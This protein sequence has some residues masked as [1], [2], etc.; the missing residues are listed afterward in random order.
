MILKAIDY[1]CRSEIKKKIKDAL[2]KTRDEILSRNMVVTIE[3]DTDSTIDYTDT[4]KG[5]DYI[6]S[7]LK[8]SL[9]VDVQ[10]GVDNHTLIARL[11]REGLNHASKNNNNKEKA[12]LF[13][14]FIKLADSS[15]YSYSTVQ[16]KKHS[17]ASAKIN[18]KSYWDSFLSVACFE[19]VYYNVIFS[20][21]SID[22]DVRGQI[23]DSWIKKEANASHGVGTQNE[24]ANELP[25]YG[26]QIASTNIISDSSSKINTPDEKSSD[27]FNDTDYLSAVERGDMKTAQKMVDEAAKAAGFTSPK[28]YHGTKSYGFT[29]FD[30]VL[31]TKP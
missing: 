8:Q 26:S 10:L 4:K 21:R 23:Y 2:N 31:K 6:K 7:I 15:I 18:E 3:D 11:T 16:D 14:K 24:S 5:R 20:V 27:R 9:G 28:L 22:S 13:N 19:D 1:C 12:A 25:N 17:V 30:L 29:E